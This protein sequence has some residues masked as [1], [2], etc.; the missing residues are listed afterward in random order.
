[1]KTTGFLT[2]RWVKRISIGLA[3]VLL[4]LATLAILNDRPLSGFDPEPYTL[5][6]EREE[7][8]NI[9]AAAATPQPQKGATTG[10]FFASGAE[11]GAYMGNPAAIYCL[12]LGYPYTTR[13]DEAGQWG[14]CSMPSGQACD[15]WAFLQGKCGAE[16]NYCGLQGYDT[17]VKS[18]GQD[19]FSREY[20]VC[21]APD[22]KELGSVAELS[23][24]G[25]KVA[26]LG[27][28]DFNQPLGSPLATPTP[29]VRPSL[30]PASPL[31]VP[32]SFDWRNYLGQNWLTGVK[33]QEGCGSC[34][35]FA[36]VGAAE[37]A[38]NIGYNNASLDLNLSEEYL[39]AGCADAG[40]CCGGYKSRALE[41]IRDSG[42]PDELC[43][44]YADGTCWCNNDVC[45]TEDCTYNTDGACSNRT[46]AD[47]CADYASRL[48]TVESYGAVAADAASIKQNLVDKGPIVV[49]MGMGDEFGGYFD[50]DIYRCSSDSSTN[51][52]VVI[53]GY[54]DVG[55]YWIVRNSWG[56]TWDGDGYFKVGYGECR[57]EGS[58]YYVVENQAP[59]GICSPTFTL[60]CGAGTTWNN[61]YF[62]STDAIDSYAC[63][64]WNESGP[65]YAYLFNS[66]TT[67][68]VTVS[69]SNMT[70]DLDIF[71]LRNPSGTCDA[72]N[73]LAYGDSTVSFTA[74]AYTIYYLVVDGYNGAVGDYTISVSCGG[75]IVPTPTPTRTLTPTPTP[76]PTPTSTAT[77]QT[78]ICV[79]DWSLAC[80]GSDQWSTTYS[81][82]TDQIDSYACTDWPETGPE[83]TYAF[84]PNLTSEVTV[85]L[86]NL[87]ADLDIFVLSSPDGTC[88]AGNCIAFGND[89]ALFTG[90]AGET[91]YLVVDGS[92]GAASTYTI[93]VAC[94]ELSRVYLPVTV[95]GR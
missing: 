42:I 85:S 9:L 23:G 13:E 68:T 92:E 38:H 3:G 71:V 69:L 56:A 94:K 17:L 52:A 74:T 44:P 21:V 64:D 4:I 70:A 45:S 62:G 41:F 2:T 77:P 86:S 18:D 82:V 6:L 40:T 88:E 60:S 63:I 48:V 24:L 75:V 76:T 29:E 93:S 31:D 73:C 43:M 51:H 55:G 95:K 26:A 30:Q 14:E 19:P 54:D 27:C 50:G 16:Y 79:P 32:T 66:S 35:A 34:W 91:Y 90:V 8:G 12:E 65:E 58:P 22:G 47:R 80:G 1:M 5:Y 57:I 83:Y 53:A 7:L 87:S 39:V 49:S 78:G 36:A 37:A 81:G 59:S 11:E 46:C 67:V 33:N 89:F 84:I 28:A 72:D 25:A 15:A 10:Q 61:S 20:G